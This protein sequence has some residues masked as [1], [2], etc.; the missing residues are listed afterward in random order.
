MRRKLNGDEK[1]NRE[2]IRRRMCSRLGTG[3][4]E[5]LKLAGFH[6]FL[7]VFLSVFRAL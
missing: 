7:L 5:L 2:R 4:G 6:R 1:K 3:P